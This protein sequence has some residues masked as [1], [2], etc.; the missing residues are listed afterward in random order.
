[1]EN[2]DGNSQGDPQRLQE[3]S[4][5]QRAGLD[6]IEAEMKA[7]FRDAEPEPRSV[8]GI[9]ARDR[10]AIDDEQTFN[11]RFGFDWPLDDRNAVIELKHRLDLTDREIR[12]LKWTGNLRRKHGVV[13]LAS[14]RWAAIFGRCLAGCA[15]FEFAV[16]VLLGMV[17]THHPLSALQ[18]LKLPLPPRLSSS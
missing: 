13:T 6:R 2:H 3:L 7:V 5:A 8:I 14:A 16:I 10:E 15:F 11:R 1:M 4:A 9:A 17:T 12:L 18:L